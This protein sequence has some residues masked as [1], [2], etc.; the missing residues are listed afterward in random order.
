MLPDLPK[1]LSRKDN[2]VEPA[3]AEERA[4][5]A[6]KAP[7]HQD[8]VVAQIMID[9]AERDA[10]AASEIEVQQERAKRAKALKRIGEM[11]ERKA[12]ADIADKFRKWDPNTSSYYDSRKGK[13]KMSL[14]PHTETTK[15]SKPHKARTSKPAAKGKGKAPGGSKTE[16]RIAMLKRANG[17]T[18]AELL[19][20]TFD[21]KGKTPEQTMAAILSKGGAIGKAY[22]VKSTVDTN[23]N[24]RYKI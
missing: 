19:K 10:K 16:R 5:F 11:K 6:A 14:H 15:T 9:A 8:A 17:A 12:A 7:K 13:P 22:N 18:I 3:T 20:A 4:E 21:G 23:G 24:R 1:F 2:P